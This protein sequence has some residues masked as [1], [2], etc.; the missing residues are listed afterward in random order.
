MYTAVNSIS[1]ALPG[2]KLVFGYQYKGQL[3]IA[4]HWN[5]LWTAMTSLGMLFGGLMCG[6][7]SDRFG[8]RIGLVCGSLCS[9]VG[10]AVEYA[11]TNPGTLLAGKIVRK[12]L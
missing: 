4:A 3:L 8:R 11:A 10:V 5:A 2:F 12:S 1:T 6:W 9:V 7:V